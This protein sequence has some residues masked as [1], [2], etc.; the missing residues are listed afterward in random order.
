MKKR[1]KGYFKKPTNT[2]QNLRFKKMIMKEF[3]FTEKRRAYWIV[4]RHSS[5]IYK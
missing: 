2:L 4:G 3:K 1:H 5:K